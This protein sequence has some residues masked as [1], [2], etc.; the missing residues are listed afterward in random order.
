MFGQQVSIADNIAQIKRFQNRQKD[1]LKEI[2]AIKEG[3]EH[4]D[5]DDP[6]LPFWRLALGYG[7]HVNRAY[8]NWAQ[9]AIAAL[10]KM[11]SKITL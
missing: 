6:N 7:E 4:Q 2:E 10:R 8:I 9:E 11:E 1:E 5:G 3:F